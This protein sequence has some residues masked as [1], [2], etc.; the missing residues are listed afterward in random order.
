MVLGIDILIGIV[1]RSPVAH[2]TPKLHTRQ[3]SYAAILYT[4]EHRNDLFGAR[5]PKLMPNA[6]RS[7]AR[8]KEAQRRVKA[9]VGAEDREGW[10]HVEGKAVEAAMAVEKEAREQ[11]QGVLQL[12]EGALAEKAAAVSVGMRG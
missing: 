12:E 5:W 10:V 3:N 2:P 9:A 8:E 1:G 6:F 11:Q 4:E 7:L